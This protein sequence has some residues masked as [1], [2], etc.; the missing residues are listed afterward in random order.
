MVSECVMTIKLYP[1][2]NHGMKKYQRGCIDQRWPRDPHRIRL[3]VQ[4]N[5][6]PKD[7]QYENCVVQSN[8]SY[9]SN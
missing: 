4:E 1:M 8:G 7:N 2:P 5:I 6:F 9:Q 3:L